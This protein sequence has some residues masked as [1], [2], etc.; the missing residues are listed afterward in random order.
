MS[1]VLSVSAVS[2]VSA[3]RSVFEQHNSYRKS[4]HA[5]VVAILFHYSLLHL[6]S[7]T[8]KDSTKHP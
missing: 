2:A 8:S 1:F 7:L 4:G 3:V 6:S 5:N